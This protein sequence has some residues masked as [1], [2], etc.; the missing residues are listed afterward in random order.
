MSPSLFVALNLAFFLIVPA[1]VAG[2]YYSD[3]RKPTL[4]WPPFDE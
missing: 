3:R 2:A 1:I 4:D